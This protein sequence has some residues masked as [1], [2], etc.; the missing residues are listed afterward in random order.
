MPQPWDHSRPGR[1]GLWATGSSWCPC[2]WQ[3]FRQRWVPRSPR[4]A[5]AQLSPWWGACICS[6]ILR[7]LLPSHLLGERGL[8]CPAGSGGWPR[9]AGGFVQT[10]WGWGLRADLRDAQGTAS[11]SRALN[12]LWLHRMGTWERGPGQHPLAGAG[13][14]GPPCSRALAPSRGGPGALPLWGCTDPGGTRHSVSAVRVLTA[15]SAFSL[16]LT[17]PISLFLPFY[18]SSAFLTSRPVGWPGLVLQSVPRQ[19][20]RP[21]ADSDAASAASVPV[22]GPSG[23]MSPS[24]GD[25][26][27][28]RRRHGNS[29][30]WTGADAL[31][32]VG[33]A[34]PG[35]CARHFHLL[36]LQ[37]G[38]SS[39]GCCPPLGPSHPAGD[40]WRDGCCELQTGAARPGAALQLARPRHWRVSAAAGTMSPSRAVPGRC[41]DSHGR[42]PGRAPHCTSPRSEMRLTLRAREARPRVRPW[43]LPWCHGRWVCWGG[44]KFSYFAVLVRERC[45]EQTR[46]GWF[47]WWQR[48]EREL[49]LEIIA[50]SFA[51]ALVLPR[52]QWQE[53]AGGTGGI[54][55]GAKLLRLRIT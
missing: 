10:P 41:C 34:A 16:L 37:T 19:T 55:T 14:P 23:G 32:P 21:H 3:G 22:S 5:P 53:L 31:A 17:F 12:P 11:R 35:L 30:G 45:W 7:L 28:A 1:M 50:L 52:W 54:N 4:W 26:R 18:G 47:G 38:T 13:P 24:P 15:W 49:S 2:P 36:P 46:G 51:E 42:G 33:E 48:K 6:S 44:K 20:S 43:S 27:G 8:V 25:E 29:G 39:R 9:G 40:W